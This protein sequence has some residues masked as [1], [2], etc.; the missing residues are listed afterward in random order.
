M[1][2]LDYIVFLG[3][4]EQICI[5]FRNLKSSNIIQQTIAQFAVIKP[6]IITYA[7]HVMTSMKK[8]VFKRLSFAIK[9]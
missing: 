4:T 2:Y 6:V 1:Y 7:Q 5:A 3:C 8:V 9:K